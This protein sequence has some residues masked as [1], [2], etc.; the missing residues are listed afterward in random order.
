MCKK[1]LAVVRLEDWVSVCSAIRRD[2]SG[3]GLDVDEG[4][5]AYLDRDFCAGLRDL[6]VSSVLS[7][8][9]TPPLRIRFI[10]I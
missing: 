4:G 8:Q 2:W 6:K 5:E 7:T 1:K 9:D 3:A 10:G